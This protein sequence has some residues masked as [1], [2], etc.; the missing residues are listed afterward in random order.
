MIPSELNE[1]EHLGAELSAAKISS[2][3][4]VGAMGSEDGDAG[5]GDAPDAEEAAGKP[6]K[7]SR[8]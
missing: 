3:E 7:K 4:S 6:K 2:A 5:D 8:F 1:G